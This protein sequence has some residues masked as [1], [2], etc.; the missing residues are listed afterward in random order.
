MIATQRL[1][2][3]LNTCHSQRS[4]FSSESFSGDRRRV[5]NLQLFVK[6][7]NQL[8][9]I[10]L[11]ALSANFVTVDCHVMPKELLKSC[12]DTEFT[13]QSSDKCIS[14]D[15]RCDGQKDCED[16]SDEDNCED[17]PSL[18]FPLPSPLSRLFPRTKRGSDKTCRREHDMCSPVTNGGANCCPCM[19]CSCWSGA[20]GLS[21]TCK[22]RKTTFDKI[23]NLFKSEC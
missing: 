16:G 23:A 22:C 2:R 14:Y 21:E 19:S 8:C 13:C 9:L 20:V 10:A 11:F 5:K 12:P 15:L 7:I 1:S 3:P 18:S 4:V 17:K 6:M